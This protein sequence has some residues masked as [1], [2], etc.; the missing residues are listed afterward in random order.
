MQE[1][2]LKPLK[3]AIWGPFVLLNMEQSSS[4]QGADGKAIGNEW[5][6]SSSEI[7]STNGVDSSLSYVCRR[8]YTIECNWKVLFFSLLF[9]QKLI[10][11]DCLFWLMTLHQ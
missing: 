10:P 6:G 4:Q 8:E 1:F 11:F 2:G 3:V 5:L 7:L 9:A